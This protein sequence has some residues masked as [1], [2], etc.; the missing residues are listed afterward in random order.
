MTAFDEFSAE[1]MER[2][3]KEIFG[4]DMTPEERKVFFLPPELPSPPDPD[5]S[6][7]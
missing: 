2:R 5:T 3:F 7:D 1:E 6:S 4:R